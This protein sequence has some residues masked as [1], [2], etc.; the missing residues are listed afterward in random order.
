MRS[1]LYTY[2]TNNLGCAI[3]WAV[4]LL[5]VATAFPARV[6]TCRLVFLGWVIGWLSA[7]IARF[8]YPPPK[9]PPHSG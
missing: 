6:H 8:V 2:M 7:T 5:I 1:R 9:R 3:V 4:I